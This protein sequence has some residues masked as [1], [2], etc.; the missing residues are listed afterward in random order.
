MITFQSGPQLGSLRPLEA[1]RAVFGKG[2]DQPP[3]VRMLHRHRLHT[4]GPQLQGVGEAGQG[5]AL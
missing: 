5:S 4:F 1:G 3:Q 2:S